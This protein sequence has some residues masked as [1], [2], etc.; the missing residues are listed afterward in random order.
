MKYSD[1]QINDVFTV[2]REGNCNYYIK[3]EFYIVDYNDPK[4][5]FRKLKGDVKVVK[6]L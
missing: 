2:E 4:K 1:L 5:A 3:K 6:V